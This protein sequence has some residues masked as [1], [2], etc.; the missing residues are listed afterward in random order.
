MATLNQ[1]VEMY[2]ISQALILVEEFRP[3]LTSDLDKH[4][5][6]KSFLCSAGEYKSYICPLL[7]PLLVGSIGPFI[8]S[9]VF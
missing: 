9:T 6:Y 4:V 2:T 5:I 1:R 3:A 7:A 8:C